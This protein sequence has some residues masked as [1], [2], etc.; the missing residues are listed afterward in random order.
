MPKAR[1]AVS[2]PIK[3]T[4]RVTLI[5]ELFD[6]PLADNSAVEWDVDIPI[7]DFEWSVG[8][9]AGPSGCG[10]ST[11]A[12]E[13][14]RGSVITSY[15]DWPKDEAIVEAFPADMTAADVAS[16]LSSVGFSSPP[17]WFR[18]YHVLSSGEQF[19]ATAARALAES[20]NFVVIDEF[21]SVVDRTAAKIG[22]CAVAK[23]TRRMK[24][25]LV[26]VTCHYDVIPWMQP[27]WVY[28]PH[29]RK[30]TRRLVQRRPSIE[31][32][33]T[34]TTPESWDLFKKHHYLNQKL[35]HR[36]AR[37]FVAYAGN[38]PAAFAAALP[39]PHPTSPGWREHRTVCLPDF[40]GVGIGNALSD[41]VASLMA[42]TGKPYRSVTAHPGMI[43]SRQRSYKWRT[44]RGPYKRRIVTGAPRWDFSVRR[45]VASFEY[46]GPV[47][48]DDAKS[49]GII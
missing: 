4:P 24:K 2:T 46:R 28:Q 3:R 5:E 21:T 47:N 33:I 36:G 19:R 45:T 16:L 37:C 49:F 40:Q 9:I 25:R 38:R 15:S 23:I 14:F 34:R 31:L 18:P 17:S 6:I 41:Y 32:E 13:I 39:F 48:Y 42:A 29:L 22:S 10:K 27:D 26:A 12:N 1:I 35:N 43:W 20:Q 30:F 8:V 11:I 7:E 44:V